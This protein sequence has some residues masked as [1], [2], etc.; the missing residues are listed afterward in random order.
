MPVTGTPIEGE[1][2]LV[3]RAEAKKQ[4]RLESDFTADDDYIDALLV[5]AQELCEDYQHR[6]YKQRSRV[7]YL[8]SFPATIRAPYPPLVI[9]TSIKYIDTAG[10]E[11][12]LDS[13]KYRIDTD[14]E[15]ARITPA[16]GQSW[17]TIRPVT[18]AIT[19]T[20]QAG[21]RAENFP[22]KYK[23]AMLLLVTHFYENRLP[24]AEIKNQGWKDLLF[25]TKVF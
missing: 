9:V 13:S 3:T 25:G 21:Y 24:I 14:S 12:T 23:H 4:L 2:T 18:N 1:A 5:A 10:D 15:P 22:T 6:T 11:Q 20:Y 17:P 19:V 8:D 16:Y 7:Y